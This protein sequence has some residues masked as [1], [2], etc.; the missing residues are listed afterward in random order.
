M[1]SRRELLQRASFVLGY[2]VTGSAAAAVLGGCDM[3]DL[4]RDASPRL[5]TAQQAVTVRAMVDHLLPATDTPGGVEL[6]VDRFIDRA[7]HNYSTPEDQQRFLDGLAALDATCQTMFRQPF[8]SL[9]TGERDDVFR[10]YEMQSPTVAP[11][12][13]GGQ[14]T[15][16]VEPPTFYRQ[17]KHLALVGYF[18]SETV[19]ETLLAYDPIPGRFEPCIPLANIGKAWAL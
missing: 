13:W 1:V 17:F 15:E 19:G 14:I 5:F 10:Y 7:L 3:V 12:I 16:V 8:V 4:G 2:A 9:T 18:T 11:T 6:L